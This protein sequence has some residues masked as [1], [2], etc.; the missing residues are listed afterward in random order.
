MYA[1]GCLARCRI[2]GAGTS[3]QS[4]LCA[5]P[6]ARADCITN[7][8]LARVCTRN[9]AVQTVPNE[10]SATTP[11]R[12]APSMRGVL[13]RPPPKTLQ[14]AR[15]SPCSG[16]LGMTHQSVCVAAIVS[17]SATALAKAIRERKFTSEQALHLTPGVGV[18]SH[19]NNRNCRPSLL[20]VQLNREL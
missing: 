10:R 18:G 9:E 20:V 15:S 1:G 6:T 2:R 14:K 13:A 8:R 17:M 3:F 5:I 16:A 4:V 11:A 19:R 7:R 12:V